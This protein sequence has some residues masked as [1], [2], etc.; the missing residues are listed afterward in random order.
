M[1]DKQ[2][3]RYEVLLELNSN[4]TTGPVASEK[5]GLSVRQTR[6]LKWRVHERGASGLLHGNVGT[7]SGNRVSEVTRN[8]IRDLLTTTYKGFGPTFAAEKLLERDGITV[9]NEWLRGFMTSEKLW[10]PHVKRDAPTHRSWRPRMP[11]VGSME[12]FDGSYHTWITGSD[13]EQCLLLSIDDATSRITKAHFDYNEGIVPVFTFWKAYAEEHKKLPKKLYVDKFS[14]YK[15]NHVN[16]VDE[17]EMMTQFERVCIELAVELIRA[18]SPQAKGRVE[19]VFGTLQDRLVKEMALAG[20]KTIQEANEFLQLYIPKHNAQF[21]V[22][23]AETE[24]AHVPVTRTDL[25]AVF[26]VQTERQ[27]QNDFTVRFENSWYQIQKLQSSTVV[28]KDKVLMEKRLDG[29]VCMRLKRTNRYLAI[30]K[31]PERPQKLKVQIQFIAASVRTVYIPGP[32][33]PWRQYKKR[34]EREILKIA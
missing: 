3:L 16:A 21:G 19:R 28:Q 10:S 26:S 13:E 15:V 32:Q 5:L 27:V 22:V 7:V 30:L 18:H 14:T 2:L 23:S 11:R 29:S 34:D 31:L 9:S 6:R 8:K 4:V 17:P 1:T 24:T 20:V 12:Q 33:H 25:D